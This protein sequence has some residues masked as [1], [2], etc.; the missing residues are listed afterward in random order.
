[1]AAYIVPSHLL[2]RPQPLPRHV[3]LEC[4]FSLPCAEAKEGKKK[5]AMHEEKE[6]GA[7]MEVL[8]MFVRAGKEKKRRIPKLEN[9]R[10]TV[11]R[12][13][14]KTLRAILQADPKRYYVKMLPTRSPA[15][16][17]V[18]ALLQA[19]VLSHSQTSSCLSLLQNGPQV[20]SHVSSPYKTYN[21]A[22][23]STVFRSIEASSLFRL[24]LSVLFCDL[25]A[26]SLC[27]RFSLR[28]C[29]SKEHSETCQR[30]WKLMSEVLSTWAEV[31]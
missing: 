3:S 13:F 29:E 21:N 31:E 17:S 20:D 4:L 16:A 10:S 15:F 1:M 9:L 23:M 27:I 18:Y 11:M 2:A 25:H 6:G 8:K 22:Y 28:C 24:F 5:G 19:Q 26:E 7:T 30:K 14:K 12:S